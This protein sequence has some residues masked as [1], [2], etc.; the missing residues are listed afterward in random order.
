MDAIFKICKNGACG[1]TV[2][3]LEKDNDEYLAEA[4]STT[5][6]AVSTRNYAYSQS[7]TVNAITSIKSTGEETLQKHTIVKHDIDCIDESDLELIIDGLYEVTHIILPTNIWLNYVISRSK[8]S[9]TAY[10]AIYYYD[11]E[12]E[13]FMKYVD[14]VSI[15]VTIEEVLEVNATPPT[16]VIDKTTTIIRSDKNTFCTCHL[17]ECFYNICKNLLSDL[18]GRCTNK[19]SDVKLLIYNRDI[20]W[21][22]INVIKYL[23]ELAQYYEAQ[24]VLEDIT[25]CGSICKNNATNIN[26]GG[27]GCGCNN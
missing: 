7:I 2:S 19:L 11:L 6:I 5:T 18:P 14:E 1:I 25:Q 8:S 27:N 3:G 16:N 23:I 24:R 21:M 15:P 9:L 10:N 13:S 12:S 17:N 22:A 26:S 20:I 4:T